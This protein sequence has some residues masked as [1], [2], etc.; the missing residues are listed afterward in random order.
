MTLCYSFNPV[1]DWF[2][3]YIVVYTIFSIF[4]LFFIWLQNDKYLKF[5]SHIILTFMIFF[6]GGRPE[7]LGTDTTLYLDQFATVTNANSL[8]D[9]PYWYRS[10]DLFNAYIKLIQFFG[11]GQRVYLFIS[12]LLF[13]IPLFVFIKKLFKDT[14]YWII[15]FYFGFFP[16]VTLELN[17]MRNSIALPLSFFAILNWSN[18][19]YRRALLLFILSGLIHYSAIFYFVAVVLTKIVTRTKI[20]FIFVLLGLVIYVLGF[21]LF[22]LITG[23]S[24]ELGNAILLNKLS[25]LSNENYNS[26]L[27]IDFILFSLLLLVPLIIYRKLG[28]SIKPLQ[29]EV[30]NIYLCIF[31]IFTTLLNMAH[32]N[33][34]A[35][36]FWMLSPILIF[37]PLVYVKHHRN[38]KLMIALI[39][40]C[41]GIINIPFY[42]KYDFHIGLQP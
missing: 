16:F 4:F 13:H 14:Y 40:I 19:K 21:D 3:L 1:Y 8:L 20:W 28:Y 32:S 17:L 7:D 26:G 15:F 33:R 22:N 29:K 42:G 39:I 2:Y 6:A 35:T 9:I 23:F 10:S 12:S 36:L 18:K 24:S 27:R 38:T 25:G 37:Y 30:L 31:A 34:V 11:G 5:L 41:F